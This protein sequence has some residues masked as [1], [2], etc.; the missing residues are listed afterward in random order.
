MTFPYRPLFLLEAESAT[1]FEIKRLDVQSQN[2]SNVYFWLYFDKASG[3]LSQLGFVSMSTEGEVHRR[4]F[5]QGRLRFDATEGTFEP[6][7][8]SQAQALRTVTPPVLPAALETAL[9][10]F[11]T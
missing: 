11:F 3:Q 4:E 8:G 5:T 7:G 2:P 6:A 1:I 9:F 10:A